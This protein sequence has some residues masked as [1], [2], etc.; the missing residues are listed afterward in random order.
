MN[1]MYEG[2]LNAKL[3]VI[4]VLEFKFL[5]LIE[6]LCHIAIHMKKE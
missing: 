5:F 3:N 4:K 2:T 1:Y 6:A